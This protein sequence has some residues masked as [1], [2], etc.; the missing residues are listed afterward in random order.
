MQQNHNGKKTKS[1]T[2]RDLEQFKKKLT[3]KE[4]KRLYVQDCRQFFG[5]WI[6]SGV[7]ISRW[8][9]W[10]RRRIRNKRAMKSKACS[11]K[12]FV[13]KNV[14]EFRPGNNLAWKLSHYQLLPLCCLIV[15]Q[16]Q[17]SFSGSFSSVAHIW[18]CVFWIKEY[19]NAY[20]VY[21]Y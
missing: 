12:T 17:L 18:N 16:N 2:H 21:K 9:R 11:K 1:V 15:R 14:I 8:S 4:R 3:T 13:P 6:S 7:C 20:F 5:L 19:A 10:K